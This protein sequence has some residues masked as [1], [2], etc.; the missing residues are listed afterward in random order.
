MPVVPATVVTTDAAA[1]KVVKPKAAPKPKAVAPKVEAKVE[2]KAEAV[3]VPK[4]ATKAPKAEVA[5]VKA[6][7]AKAAAPKE[8]KPV[9][10]TVRMRG[11]KALLTGEMTAAEV[12]EAIG[13]SHSL[14]LTLDK[15]V[16]AGTL[17]IVPP[18]GDITVAKY[19]LTAAGKKI[20]EK[21]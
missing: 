16:T 20:A 18:K 5:A 1:P 15:E 11:L 8:D 9:K 2:P 7:K 17:V 14:K 13:L 12:Q 6:P 4:K 10:V 21:L 3:T 19:K